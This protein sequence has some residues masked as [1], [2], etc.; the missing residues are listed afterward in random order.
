[1]I[2]LNLSHPL[3]AEQRQQIETLA[4]QPITRLI[5]RMAQFDLERPFAEQVITLVESLGLAPAEWQRSPL[6]V[7]LPSLNFGAAATLAELHGRCGY[8]P[9]IVR[10]RPVSGS[11]PPRYEVAEI[12]NLQGLRDAARKRRG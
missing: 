9:P 2:L 8:F 12:V 10:L 1:M 3:T 5:E 7:N 11:L 6:L 4:G